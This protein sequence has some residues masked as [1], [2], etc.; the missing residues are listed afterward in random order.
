M[1]PPIQCSQNPVTHSEI[2]PE[3]SS[4][5]HFAKL[6]ELLESATWSAVEWVEW[7]A[8]GIYE[9]E[10]GRKPSSDVKL[11]K[12]FEFIRKLV[13][14]TVP[15]EMLRMRVESTLAKKE[16]MDASDNPTP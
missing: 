7:W 8:T 4:I 11:Q 5:V 15:D 3:C 6:D 2:P 10:F 13:P 9:K 1:A 14:L 16:K 12:A